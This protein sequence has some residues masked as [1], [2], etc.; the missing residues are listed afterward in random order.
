MSQNHFLRRDYVAA[1]GI[2]VKG[3]LATWTSKVMSNNL[4][5]GSFLELR[6]KT[7]QTS[8]TGNDYTYFWDP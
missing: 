3:L 4:L 2:P 6:A 7:S 5:L 1:R 8:P